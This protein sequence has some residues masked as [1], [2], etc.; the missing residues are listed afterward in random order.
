MNASLFRIR[1]EGP[2]DIPAISHLIDFAFKDMP[3]AEGD[4]ADLVVTLRNLGGLSVSLVA[5][6]GDQVVGHV[7]LSPAKAADSSQGWYGLGP[8]AVLPEHQGAGL[9]SRLLKAGLAVIDGFA[10]SGCILVGYPGLY[11][12]AGFIPAPENAPPGE[13]PEFFMVKLFRGNLP[14]GPIHFHPAFTHAA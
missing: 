8:I 5:E 6:L 4:E 11:S 2:S 9:G 1:S 12:R 14:Q 3:Y 13:P 10:A 7:A